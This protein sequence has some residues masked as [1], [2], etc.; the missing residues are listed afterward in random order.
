MGFHGG[1]RELYTKTHLTQVSSGSCEVL[2]CT[3]SRSN[4]LAQ[5]VHTTCADQRPVAP[6]RTTVRAERRRAPFLNLDGRCLHRQHFFVGRAQL[7]LLRLSSPIDDPTHWLRLLPHPVG[8]TPDSY[9]VTNRAPT[10]RRGVAD[11]VCSTTLLVAVRP[12]RAPGRSS[13]G[14]ECSTAQYLLPQRSA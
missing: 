8:C 9:H 5:G 10:T 7:L 13:S 4:L 3:T 14:S 12:R 11:T 2:L 1:R 6:E